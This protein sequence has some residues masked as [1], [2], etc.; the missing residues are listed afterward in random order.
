MI[1]KS[2]L[3]KVKLQRENA[4]LAAQATAASAEQLTKIDDEFLQRY[5]DLF[6]GAATRCLH[7]NL[8]KAAA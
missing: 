4:A 8:G 7:T 2:D 3:E 6:Y 5:F 1:D